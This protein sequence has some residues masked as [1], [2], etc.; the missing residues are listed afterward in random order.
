ML[1]NRKGSISLIIWDAGV[2]A[3][4]FGVLLFSVT[5]R[6]YHGHGVA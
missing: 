3:I 4:T 6:V 1:G 2:M 5:T